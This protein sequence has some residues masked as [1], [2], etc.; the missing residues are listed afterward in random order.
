MLCYF[1][2]SIFSSQ[3]SF[4]KNINDQLSIP[5]IYISTDD[6]STPAETKEDKPT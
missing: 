1:N 6:E 5:N 2:Y 4:N 3:T